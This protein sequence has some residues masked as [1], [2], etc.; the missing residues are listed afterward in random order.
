[1]IRLTVEARGGKVA[2]QI[3]AL[4]RL[5]AEDQRRFVELLLHPPELASAMKRAKRAHSELIESR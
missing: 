5:S 1:V 2:K 3:I 4:I